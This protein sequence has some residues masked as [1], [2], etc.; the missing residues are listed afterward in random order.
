MKFCILQGISVIATVLL[1]PTDFSPN[2]K[3]SLT[4]IFIYACGCF[5]IL[6]CA[7]WINDSDLMGNEKGK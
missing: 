6:A 3:L 4:D 1:I 7:L 2:E 5:L